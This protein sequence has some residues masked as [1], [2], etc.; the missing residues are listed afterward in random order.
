M[1]TSP[2]T[3]PATLTTK[4]TLEGWSKIRS[5]G[6]RASEQPRNRAKGACTGAPTAAKPSESGSEGMTTA[7]AE[8]AA[9]NPRASSA[10]LR[11]ARK[12][13]DEEHA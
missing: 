13:R 1:H 4:R 10:R 6:A 5:I 3:L 11:V 8:E 7:S 12:L 9:S 2:S